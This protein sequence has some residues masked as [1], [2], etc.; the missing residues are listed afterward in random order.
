M[1]LMNPDLSN[2]L[3][4]VS[5]EAAKGDPRYNRNY[6]CN[7]SVMVRHRTCTGGKETEKNIVVDVGE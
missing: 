5:R 3:T 1:H 4:L 7:P 2:P 6:R